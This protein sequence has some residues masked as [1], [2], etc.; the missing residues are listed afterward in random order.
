MCDPL[1]WKIVVGIIVALVVLAI[2]V[3]SARELPATRRY[4]RIKRM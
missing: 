1:A 2:V 3:M 4:L